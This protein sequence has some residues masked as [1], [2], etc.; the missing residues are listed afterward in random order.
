MKKYF[1]RQK[2]ELVELVE[3]IISVEKI[4]VFVY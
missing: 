4:Q 2:V 3:K 1:I